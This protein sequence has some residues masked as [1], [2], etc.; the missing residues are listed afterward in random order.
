MDLNIHILN[1]VISDVNSQILARSLKVLDMD[2]K[3]HALNSP[4]HDVDLKI[5]SPN[6]HILSK[7]SNTL[8]QFEISAA[9]Q[10]SVA[11]IDTKNK[12]HRSGAQGFHL[13]HIALL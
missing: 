3:V 9:V 4:I 2:S 11:G 1:S 10:G 5:H 13:R 7:N 12:P 6:S 8:C